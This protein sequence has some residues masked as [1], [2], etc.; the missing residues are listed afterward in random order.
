MN[1]VFFVFLR[2][3]WSEVKAFIDDVYNWLMSLIESI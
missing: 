2:E 3:N 1:N